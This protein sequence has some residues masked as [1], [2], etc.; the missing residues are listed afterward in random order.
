MSNESETVF[1]DAPKRVEPDKIKWRKIDKGLFLGYRE[2]ILRHGPVVVNLLKINPARR[3]IT[4]IDSSGLNKKERTLR[5]LCKKFAAIAGT[6]GGFSLFS[7]SNI[8]PPGKREV[9]VGLIVTDGIVVNPP[10]F[11]RS[12]ILID[13]ETHVFIKQI[14]MKGVSVEAGVARFTARKVNREI[15]K[16]EIGVFTTVWGDY[17]P[18]IGAMHFSVIG[19]RVA[20]VSQKKLRIPI[21][22]FAVVVNPGGAPLGLF[23]RIEK[24]DPVNYKLP[25]IKGMGK[26]ISAMAG[27]PALLVNRKTGLDFESEQFGEGIPPVTFSEDSIIAHSSLPRIAW[28]VTEF[29]ELIACAVR[30]GNSEKSQGMTLEELA[31]FMRKLGCVNAVNLDGGATNKMVVKGISVDIPSR[32]T[33]P[34]NKIKT[35]KRAISSAI[36]IK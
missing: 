30:G 35:P 15:G 26:V 36:L 17:S 11:N 12:A 32:G 19:R 6:S 25:E 29:H 34:G 21:N 20:A 18:E 13:D 27:G 23:E 10:V 4:T 3:E 24:G 16:G 28:G 22:G 7:E 1:P 33:V 5:R 8:E 14:G 2:T 31:K 9:P